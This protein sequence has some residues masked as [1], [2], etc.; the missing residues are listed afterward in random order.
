MNSV[1]K[2]KAKLEA[3]Q[4]QFRALYGAISPMLSSIC[5]RGDNQLGLGGLIPLIPSRFYDFVKN[6]FHRCINNVVAYVRVVAP[7]APLER[8]AESS[9]T[10]EFT[11]QVEVAKV[12]L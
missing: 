11:R 8:L 2:L 5:Q 10:A 7:D 6:D 9:V 4:S 3:S 12:D 1:Q